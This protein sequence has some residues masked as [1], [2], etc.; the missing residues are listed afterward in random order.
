MYPLHNFKLDCD[1]FERFTINKHRALGILTVFLF[2]FFITGAVA[3]QD[4]GVE[5]QGRVLIDEVHSD[6]ESTLQKMDKEWYG[7]LSTYNYYSLAEWLNHS[8]IVEKNTNTTLHSALLTNYDILIIKC[9]T[10][11]FSEDE[12]RSI[13]SFVENGGGLFLIGDHTNVFGM[14]LYLNKIAREFGIEFNSDATHDLKTGKMSVYKPSETLPHP[15]VQSM[16]SFHFLTSCSLNAPLNAEMVMV[17]SGLLGVPGTYTT[18]DFFREI[19]VQKPDMN[20]GFFLQSVALKYGKG[21]VVAF[22]DST[23]FS[24]FCMFMDG[25]PA[26]V[27]GSMDYLNRSNEFGYINTL[28]Y[29]FAIINLGLLLCFFRKE[30]KVMVIVLVVSLGVFSYWTAA[31]TFSHMNRITYELPEPRSDYTTVCFDQEHSDVNISPTASVELFPERKQYS[32]FFVWTQRVDCIPSVEETLGN[33]IKNGDIVVIIN[34]KA[35]FEKEDIDAVTDYVDHGGNVLL[36]DSIFNTGSTAN[37]LLQNFGI[38]ITL[39]STDRGIYAVNDTITNATENSS[40]S[41]STNSNMTTNTSTIGTVTRP[42]LS[43]V[44]G[45]RILMSEDNETSVAVAEIRNETSGKTGK[46]VVMVD[47]YTFSD[48]VMGGPLADPDEMQMQ[49]YN[50]EFYLFEKILLEWN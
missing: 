50:T 7:T 30:K 33:A 32:T 4:P 1:G 49:I 8:Y 23:C 37:E 46:I 40:G 39:K 16:S 13:I 43:I 35:P 17:D 21:R 45:E 28:F 2:F 18:K 15:I 10:S 19:G 6:W 3:F 36:M 34:P 48:P 29:A 27:L 47:S 12:V 42:F 26:Y 44:G 11:R 22:T 5:K 38:W 9:P 20:Y 31:T 25:Y 14:N 41:G 24:N